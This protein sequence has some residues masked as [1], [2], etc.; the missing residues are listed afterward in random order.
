MVI[1]PQLRGV[2]T[3]WRRDARAPVR[4]SGLPFFLVHAVF[5]SIFTLIFLHSFSV[6]L[7][8]FILEIPMHKC[9][10]KHSCLSSTLSMAILNAPF[11]FR[12][13]KWS[14]LRL[15]LRLSKQNCNNNSLT[16]FSFKTFSKFSPSKSSK[17]QLIALTYLPQALYARKQRMAYLKV[18]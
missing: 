2:A 7:S 5:T 9:S 6:P 3:P 17:T 14:L 8:Y 1:Q 4:P 12:E 10:G 11:F 16:A 13:T 15:K 18:R